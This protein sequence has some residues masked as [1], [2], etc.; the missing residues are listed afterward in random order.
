MVNLEPRASV[1]ATQTNPKMQKDPFVQQ[2][3]RVVT[4]GTSILALLEILRKVHAG[5]ISE[6]LAAVLETYRG[7]MAFLLW[8]LHQLAHVVIGMLPLD[9][10]WQLELAG[11]WRDYFVLFFLAVAADSEADRRSRRITRWPIFIL[12]GLIAFIATVT[13]DLMIS[14]G[15]DRL[16][17]SGTV[18]G[19]YVFYSACRNILLGS[20]YPQEDIKGWTTLNLMYRTTFG[21][22]LICGVTLMAGWILHSLGVSEAGLASFLCFMLLLALRNIVQSEAFTFFAAVRAG[23][24]AKWFSLRTGV[25][26]LQIVVVLAI[27]I[28]I[29]LGVA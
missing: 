8:P 14:A 27:A 15:A 3:L 23:K 10:P 16:V 12:G 20:L 2:V 18:M 29:F 9:F 5:E 25:F 19:G 1:E 6:V 13:A 22:A 24:R 26:G 4:F 17:A 11:D 21:E 28:L 7:V